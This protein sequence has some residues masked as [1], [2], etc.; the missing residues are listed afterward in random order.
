MVSNYYAQDVFV[1][2]GFHKYEGPTTIDFTMKV[3]FRGDTDNY[4]TVRYSID[5]NKYMLK[6]DIFEN[7]LPAGITT[8]LLST[9]SMYNL[10]PKIVE[11]SILNYIDTGGWIVVP[12]KH[13]WYQFEK[14][15]FFKQSKDDF[16]DLSK[17]SESLPGI[18][19]TFVKFP[20]GCRTDVANLKTIIIHLNDKDK[21]PREKIADWLDDLAD[22]GIVDIDFKTPTEKT[23]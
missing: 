23:V 21:W 17:L 13:G 6:Y 16:D 11:V 22:R 7:W 12:D 5:Y 10:D 2:I 19:Y 15:P 14:F 20:C 4:C 18:L 9:I 3:V 8:K 1:V